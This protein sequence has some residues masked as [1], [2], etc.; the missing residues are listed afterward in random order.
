MF[1]TTNPSMASMTFPK[2]KLSLSFIEAA[3]EMRALLPNTK[4]RFWS[5]QKKIEF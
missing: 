3:M 2:S 1:S 5:I 4:S